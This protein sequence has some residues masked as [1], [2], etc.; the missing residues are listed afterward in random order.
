MNPTAD[1]RT[2]FN[3]RYLGTVAAVALVYFGAAK[4]GLSLA[5][6]TK[7]V[8]A[9]WP[10]TGIAVAALLLGGYRVWPAIYL[11]AFAVNAVVGDSILAAAGIAVGNTLG[12]VVARFSLGRL[13]DFDPALTRVRDVLGLIVLGAVLGAAVSATNGV[14]TLALGAVIPW[15]AYGSVWWVWWV[16]DAM[17][18]LVFAPLILS[19]AAQPRPTWD[20][21]QLAELGALFG[22]LLLASLV[23]LAG[24]FVQAT[25]PFQLQYAVFPFIIWAGLRFGARET[26]L[27]AALV[28]GLAVWGAVH[29]HGLFATGN[30]DQRLILLEMFMAVVTVTGFTL[31]AVNA[32][33]T[34]AQKALQ[35]ANDEL[36][37]R[38]AERTA[39]LLG[40]VTLLATAQERLRESEER[41]RGAFEFAAIGMALVAPDGRWLRVNR[42]VCRI[43]GY[44]AEELLATDFQA[45]THPDDLETDVGYVRQMLDGSLSHYDMEKRYFHKDGHI[46]WILLS[47]SLVRDTAGRPLYF[48][49]QIHDITEQRQLTEDLR[50]ARADLRAILDNV[51]A[52]ITSWHA[53]STNHFVNQVAAA[54]FGLPASEAVGKHAQEIIGPERYARAKIHID[55]ALAGERQS[56]EQVDSLPDGSVRYS[57]VEF[58][59]KHQDGNVVGF[60]ALATDVT[61][62]R[63]SY[64][65]I[66][67]LARRLETVRENERRSLAQVLHDGIAQDLF[68]MKL[69]LSYLQAQVTG[70]AGVSDACR[71]LAEAIDKCMV[72]TRL[73]AN[74]LRPSALAH[75]PVSVALKEHAR[76]FGEIS[77]LTI[78]VA[79]IA[80]VPALDEATG[81]ML[82]RAAQEALTNVARHA[83]ASSIDIVLRADA[84]FITMDITDDG[85]GIE[86]TA[87]AKAGSLG[88]LGIQERID[89]LGG[90]LLL[91]KSAGAGT[92]VSVRLPIGERS[93]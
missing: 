26:G 70:R 49:S 6:S 85:I 12:P 67:E 57:Q 55:A 23:A 7:Q 4:F 79:E 18:I 56:Y 53:D 33:R 54:Q 24:V 22:G 21:A 89:A 39:E 90:A 91:R 83:H 5:F 10:P 50:L 80:P 17:G 1:T 72:A 61:E 43:V 28:T 11:A 15:S 64:R 73:I 75:L 65:R 3:P 13:G 81:L 66:R 37:E 82:F 78:R 32:E 62:L 40:R 71:E 68:A 42:S 69:G 46:I 92:T 34:Q 76:Y 84:E 44:T 58:V 45:I 36:G 14:A 38:I 8:T 48:V 59:P 2:W 19:W 88:L 86:E 35:R 29:G 25:T 16:G 93:M 52:Q 51:P 31:S 74:E 9:L 41:F 47:V 77:G 27:A 20:G 63:E 60:Y 30:L 87:L